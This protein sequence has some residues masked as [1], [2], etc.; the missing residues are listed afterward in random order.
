MKPT[1]VFNAILLTLCLI[2]AVGCDQ[3][4]ETISSEPVNNQTAPVE[5]DASFVIPREIDGRPVSVLKP[6]LLAS[7]DGFS[8]AKE[9]VI[10]DSV[11]EIGAH[12]FAVCENLTSVVIP[13]SVTTIG[14]NAF[15]HCASLTSVA[16][17]N[18][19]TAIGDWAFGDCPSLTSVVIPASVTEIGYGAFPETCKIERR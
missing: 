7:L 14:D 5:N 10:P 9:V 11:T 6:E 2:F 13:D 4:Q 18:S 1:A 19:V 8:E 16:I 15:A 12:A 3:K 17:P